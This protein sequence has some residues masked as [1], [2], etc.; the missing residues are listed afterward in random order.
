MTPNNRAI[1]MNSKVFLLSLSLVA[2]LPWGTVSNEILGQQ[3]KNSQ[4]PLSYL[5]MPL[6]SRSNPIPEGPAQ[7]NIS[8][9]PGFNEAFVRMSGSL[10]VVVSLLLGLVWFTRKR[11]SRLGVQLGDHT[12]EIIGQTN[13]TKNHS[14]HVVK[15]GERL[16]LVSAG[17][18]DVTCLT[19]IS[20]PVE[21]EQLLSTT[22]TKDSQRSTFKSLFA[23]YEQNPN[24]LFTDT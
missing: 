21:V 16:L 11:G 10:A 2:L 9:V 3:K 14:L 20:D 8:A 19:E 6:Q 17:D 1:Q 22:E 7:T 18:T 4:E 12:L 15:L 24:Q 13:L 5:N 23:Q